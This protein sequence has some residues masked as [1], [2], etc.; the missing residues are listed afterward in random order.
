LEQKGKSRRCTSFIEKDRQCID[1]DNDL[2]RRSGTIIGFSHSIPIWCVSMSGSEQSLPLSIHPDPTLYVENKAAPYARIRRVI[3]QSDGGVLGVTGERGA[4]KSVLLNKLIADY[5]NDFLTVNLSAPISSSRETEFFV[6][7]FRYLVQQVIIKLHHRSRE[8]LD[9]IEE[10]G[11]LDQRSAWRRA[12]IAF[13]IIYLVV[14]LATGT[15]FLW[16]KHQR[17]VIVAQDS[18]DRIRD[19]STLYPFV[20]PV[21]EPDGPGE[22][23]ESGKV[24]NQTSSST[25]LGPHEPLDVMKTKRAAYIDSAKQRLDALQSQKWPWLEDSTLV[26]TLLALPLTLLALGIGAAALP[27]LKWIRRSRGIT[28]LERGLLLYSQRTAARLDYELTTKGERGFEVTPFGWLKGNSK[29]AREEKARPL[30]LPELTTNYIEFVSNVLR[31]FPGKLIICIDELDKVSDLDHVRFILREIKGA[32]YVKN[33]FYVLSISSDALRSFEGRLGDQRDIF[34]STFDDVFPVRHLDLATC[35]AILNQRLAQVKGDESLPF[36]VESTLTLIALSA[37]G[38]ARELIRSFR[39]CVL[40]TELGLLPSLQ[41][42]WTLLFNR[43]ADAIRD[44]AIVAGGSDRV[45]SIFLPLLDFSAQPLNDPLNV[46]RTCRQELHAFIDEHTIDKEET[47]VAARF[48]RY[49]V[50]IEI[51]LQA[52]RAA[53][54]LTDGSWSKEASTLMKA[55]Q[56]LP[57]SVSDAETILDSRNEIFANTRLDIMESMGPT[58][59]A[60]VSDRVL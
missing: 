37:A 30:S 40:S 49:A 25:T 12:L 36:D 35:L 43:R 16:Y 9:D 33:T 59:S 53:F 28:P 4:G 48:L 3:D 15:G 58:L 2:R 19:F 32:L 1:R 47:A 52:R 22:N 51:F 34:E 8:H 26:R 45:R 42:A 55:Y 56:I 13:G 31:V 23:E 7:L 27:F 5:S 50:E 18:L 39:D 11:I 10:I 46:W 38:N 57:F 29:F 60:P 54:S 6:M 14:I 17:A 20:I 44:R 41:V 21:S 24:T